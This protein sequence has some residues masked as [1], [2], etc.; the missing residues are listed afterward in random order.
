MQHTELRVNTVADT[1]ADRGAHRAA[2]L[3]PR[4]LD[5]Q[6]A[7]SAMSYEAVGSG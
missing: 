4:A 5:A 2:S 6:Y 1:A 3:H 7:V